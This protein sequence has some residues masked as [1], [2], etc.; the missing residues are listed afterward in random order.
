MR[1][2]DPNFFGGTIGF[3]GRDGDWQEADSGEKP[4]GKPNW[5]SPNWAPDAPSRAN[6]RCLGL[7]EMASAVLSGTPHRTSGHMAQHVLEVMNA[8]L[9]AGA[10]G[11]P[12]T[13]PAGFERPPA[14]TDDAARALAA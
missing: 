7:A 5:R 8:I 1:V 14:L 2:P 3:T 9:E 4:F 12:V 11:T 10:S 6:Y 13:V